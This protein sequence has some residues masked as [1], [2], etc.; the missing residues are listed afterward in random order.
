MPTMTDFKVTTY[1]ALVGIMDIEA[2]LRTKVGETEVAYKDLVAAFGE[3]CWEPDFNDKKYNFV[4]TCEW[5]FTD[6]D[7]NIFVLL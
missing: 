6:G 3:P 4:S 7:N 1:E 5:L 2:I